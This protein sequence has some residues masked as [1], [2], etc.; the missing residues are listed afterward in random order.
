[1]SSYI[2]VES[3]CFSRGYRNIFDGLTLSIPRGKVTAIM[4]PSGIGKTTLLKL[5]GGQLRPDSGRVLVDGQDFQ[6]LSREDLFEA[7][8]K[9]GMLFQSGA[10]F[11]DISVFENVAFP[12]RAHTNLPEDMIRD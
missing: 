11:S 12:L 9:M 2:E 3:L 5:I 6:T 7:R 8:S 4:G 10:L 1:M